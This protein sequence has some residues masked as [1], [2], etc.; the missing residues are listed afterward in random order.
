MHVK[1]Q[2][3]ISSTFKDLEEERRTV[4]EQVLNLGHIPVGMELFQA[5]DETQWGLHQEEDTCV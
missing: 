3:F 5:G 2:V 1:Y 4:I